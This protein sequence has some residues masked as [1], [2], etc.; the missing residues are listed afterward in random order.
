MD[1]YLY[2]IEYFDS[3]S[4]GS[5]WQTYTGDC[6]SQAVRNFKNDNPHAKVYDVF[7]QHRDACEFIETE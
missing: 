2:A 4:S 3:D 7:V 1:T 6:I 5:Q